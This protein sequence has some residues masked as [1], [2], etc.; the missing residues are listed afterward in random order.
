MGFGFGL[1]FLTAVRGLVAGLAGVFGVV[2]LDTDAF[3]L[4]AGT[5]L[6]AGFFTGAAGFLVVLR[7]AGFFPAGCVAMRASVPAR[8][9]LV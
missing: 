4:G 7:G 2:F 3:A 9:D 1:A 6:P 5:A 8:G